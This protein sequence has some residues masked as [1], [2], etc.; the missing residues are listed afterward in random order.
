MSH[1]VVRFEIAGKDGQRLASFYRDL[2]GWDIQDAGPDYWLVKG[3]DGGI[4]GGLF[5]TRDDIPSYVTVYVSTPDLNASLE[6]AVELGGGR[7]VEPMEIPS[8]GTFAMVQD[9]EGNVIGLLAER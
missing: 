1:P 3:E 6:R 2:F 7:L 8:A 4:G 9:P 5:K